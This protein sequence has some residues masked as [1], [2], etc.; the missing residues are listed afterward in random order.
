MFTFAKPSPEDSR[1][2]ILAQQGQS[3]SYPAVGA[4]R[5]PEKQPGFDNDYNEI[6]LGTG[7]AVFAKAKE[8]IRQ[9]RMF[10]GGWA[11]IFPEKTP[12]QTGQTVAMLARV[13]GLW[14]K[15]A[16]RIVYVIDE[17]AH[18]GF[19]YGTLPGHVERGEEVFAVRMDAD[20]RVFYYI[21]ALSQPRHW[22]ARLGYPLARFYQ[23]KFV[24]ESKQ[25]MLRFVL[26]H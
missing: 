26:N 4:T 13:A 24:R 8:G 6:D 19:A 11:E 21:K 15:N 10:P 16:C 23:R 1:Q 2:F 9:W 17:P 22:M 3:H 12:I 20:G 18:F 25:S 5:R 7:E 14:W